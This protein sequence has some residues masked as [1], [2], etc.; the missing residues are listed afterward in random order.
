MSKLLSPV[1]HTAME[2][3][4]SNGR[5]VGIVLYF[6]IIGLSRLYVDEVT[7][8]ERSVRSHAKR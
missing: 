4:P 8:H 6:I 3:V 7:L 2:A 1:T 5:E